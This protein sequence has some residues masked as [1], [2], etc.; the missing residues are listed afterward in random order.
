MRAIETGGLVLTGDSD[1]L[2]FSS[3]SPVKATASWGVVMF[4]DLNLTSTSTTARV[5]YPEQIAARLQ[6]P[7]ISLAYQISIDP[8]ASLTQVE[9]RL[10]RISLRQLSGAGGCGDLIP[11]AFLAEYTLHRSEPSLFPWKNQVADPR[12]GELLFLASSHAEEK[13]MYLPF[14]REDPSRACAWDV[15]CETRRFAYSLLFLAPSTAKHVTVSEVLRRGAHIVQ[16]PVEGLCIDEIRL[17]VEETI[18]LVRRFPNYWWIAIVLEEACACAQSKRQES[19]NLIDLAKALMSSGGGLKIEEWTWQWV[20][21][22]AWAQAGWYSLLML[23]EV[24]GFIEYLFIALPEAATDFN[25]KELG[26]VLNRLPN[27]INLFD[28]TESDYNEPDGE[29]LAIIR[30]VMQLGCQ[31][32]IDINS[33]LVENSKRNRNQSRGKTK[34]QERKR[35]G[36]KVRTNSAFR[37]NMFDILAEE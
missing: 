32:E 8:H 30:D 1:L 11:T 33:S 37:N 17:R 31:D 16:S 13:K 28:P 10:K 34:T 9:E 29:L 20:H 26:E 24:V 5:F 21:V 12:I 4:Q 15:G 22:C 36:M 6:H 25:L 3:D 14:L 18:E 7:I 2:V 27:M 23:K 19:P 35:A